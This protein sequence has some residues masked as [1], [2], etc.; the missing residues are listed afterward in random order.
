MIKIQFLLK[1]SN[2]E[3]E[4]L[5]YITITDP[6]IDRSQKFAWGHP[7]VCEVYFSD[8]KQNF[9][10]RSISPIDA[11]FQ[12]VKTAKNYLQ[13]LFTNGC[14]ISEA[15]SKEPWNLEKLSD[16][17]LEEEVNRIK[18]NPNISQEDKQKILKIVKES[19]SKTVIGDQLNKAIDKN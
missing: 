9:L 19:F 14:V 10:S 2:E 4:N 3:Q 15:E 13:G 7:Y 1:K 11:L 12:A 5:E 18:N 17:F 16:E 8:M 6:K